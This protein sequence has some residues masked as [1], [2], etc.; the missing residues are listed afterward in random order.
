MYFSG[1]NPFKAFLK[2]FVFAW[3]FYFNS[4]IRVAYA[5]FTNNKLRLRYYGG[6]KVINVQ[7]ANEFLK[8]KINGSKPFMFGR[9]GST[10]I[11]CVTEFLLYKKGI[12]DE[13]NLKRIE[14]ACNH[15]GLFPLKHKTIEDFSKLMLDLSKESDLYGTFRMI[16]EDYYIKYYMRKDVVLTHL[17]MMDFWLYDEPFTYALKG[18]KVLVIHPLAEQIEQQY[19]KRDLLFNNKKVLPEFELKTIK[20]VQTI[21]GERDERFKDWFE[22]LDYMYNQAMEIDFDVA[23]LGCGAYG[24]PLAAKIKKA[25]KIAIHMGGVTQMLFGIKGARWDMH[26]EASKLYND[27]WIRPEAKDIPKNAKDV[28]EGCYW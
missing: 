13:I 2:D 18:K 23:I 11:N 25:G 6:G 9:Y 20:A 19:A 4:G 22:A 16:M 3:Y 1:I 8:T 10:E 28:E 27:Y 15:N 5:K 26:P 21:A 12:V 7:E 17:Y 24:F 14:I